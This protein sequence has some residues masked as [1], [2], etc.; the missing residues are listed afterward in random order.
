MQKSKNHLFLF[1]YQNTKT[2]IIKI[3]L[4][5]ILHNLQQILVISI[6]QN[7]IIITITMKTITQPKDKLFNSQLSN[8]MAKQN[9]INKHSILQHHIMIN[10]QV[11]SVQQVNTEQERVFCSINCCFWI[12]MGY[13]YII[14]CKNNQFKV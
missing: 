7:I 12:K 2:I 9:S 4:K 1:F 8:L 11:L 13:L 3:I 10:L 6:T 14:I 5:K